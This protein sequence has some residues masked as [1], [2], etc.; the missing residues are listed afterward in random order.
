MAQVQAG[1]IILVFGWAHVRRDFVT[2]G[3]GWEELKPWALAWL[4]RIREWDR[5]QRQRLTAAAGR[6]ALQAANAA[7]RQTVAAMHAQAATELAD[8]QFRQPCRTVLE[9][10]P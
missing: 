7:V 3:K 8:A 6:A 2:V 9:S 10:L 5:P 1:T 4:Q